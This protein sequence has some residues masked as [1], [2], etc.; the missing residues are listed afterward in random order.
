MAV[1]K[2]DEGYSLSR[3]ILKKLVL[4][5]REKSR[6]SSFYYNDSETNRS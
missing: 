4:D 5:V 1:T 3:K 2:T 6:L